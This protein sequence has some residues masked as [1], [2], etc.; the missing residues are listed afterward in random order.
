MII[1]CKAI[2]RIIIINK[3]V[4][5]YRSELCLNYFENLIFETELE[6]LIWAVFPLVFKP[7]FSYG[8][9]GADASAFAS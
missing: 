5:N 3:K 9:S 1:N 4:I 6:V 2:Y 8:K 7:N